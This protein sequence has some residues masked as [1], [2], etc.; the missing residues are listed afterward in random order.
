MVELG[1]PNDITVEFLCGTSACQS[2]QQV[3]VSD[4]GSFAVSCQ[5]IWEGS[6]EHEISMSDGRG[7]GWGEPNK[8]MLRQIAS[9][10]NLLFFVYTARQTYPT[11]TDVAFSAVTDVP[12]P[13][14]IFWNFGDATTARTG[15]RNVT[16]RYDTPGRY[17][18]TVALSDGRTSLTSGALSIL[19]QRPVKLNKLVHRASVLRNQTTTVSCRVDSGTDVTFLWSFGDGTTKMGQ[20]VERHAFLSTGEFLMEVTVSNRVSRGSLNSVIFVLDRPCRPPPVKN[21]GPLKLQVRRHNIIRLGVSYEGDM[22]CDASRGLRY[23]WTLSDSAGHVLP[24]PDAHKQL[25]VLP[26]HLLHHDTYTAVARVEVVGNVVYSN[27][28][29]RLEMI[30]SPPVASIQG[31]TN[32]FINHANMTALTLDG[33]RSY[34]PDFPTRPLSVKWM[35]QPVSSIKS[36]CF[37]RHVATGSAVLTFPTSSLQP[38]FDQFQFTLSVHSGALS[39]STEAFVTL[40]PSVVGRLAV[41]CL[42]CEGDQVNWDQSIS[43][44]AVCEDCEVPP[45]RIAYTWTLHLVNASSKSADEVPFCYTVDLSAP[46]A[47]KETTSMPSSRLHPHPPNSSQ[48]AY[49]F[50]AFIPTEAINTFLT[51]TTNTST[52]PPAPLLGTDVLT[53]NPG[54][55]TSFHP[56]PHDSEGSNLVESRPRQGIWKQTLIDLPREPIDARSFASYT[57]TGLSSALLSFRPFSLKPGHMYMLEAIASDRILGRT[58]L[59][60]RTKPIPKGMTCQV[61]PSKGLELYTHFGIF[62]TS[63]REDLLYEYS[64]SVGSEPPRMLYQGR[65]FQYYFS[66]PSGHPTN[67]YKVTVYTKIRSSVYGSSTQ[68]CPVTVQVRPSFFRDV[69][70]PNPDVVLSQSGLKNLSALIVLGDSTEICNYVSLLSG[71]LNRLSLDSQADHRTQSHLRN[72]LISALCKLESPDQLSRPS[73]PKRYQPDQRTLS[74]L[75]AVLSCSLEAA[76]T[77]HDVTDVTREVEPHPRVGLN[78]VKG[79]TDDDLQTSRSQQLEQLVETI[80]QTASDLILVRKGTQSAAIDCELTD[81]EEI[82][83][84]HWIL[85]MNGPVVDLTLY[86]CSTRRKVSVR[87]LVRPITVEMRPRQDKVSFSPN[88]FFFNVTREHLHQAIQLSVAFTPPPKRSFPITLLFRMFAKPSPGMHHLHKIHH[89]E[90]N[91]T[92]ITL[93]P[94]YLKTPGVGYLALFNGDFGKTIRRKHQSSRINYTLAVVASQCLSLD[95]LKGAWTP[96]GCST[97]QADSTRAVNSSLAIWCLVAFVYE[98]ADLDIFLSEA[99]D[100]TVPVVLFLCVCLYAPALMGCRRADIVSEQSRRVHYLHDNCPREPHLYA[101][102]VHTGLRS[103]YK[104]SAK[105]YVALYG[106]DGTSQTRELSVPGCTLFR[107]NSRDTFVLS[108][109]ESL[110]PVWGVRIWHDN[111]GPSPHLFVKLVEVSELGQANMESPTRLFAGQCWLSASRGDGRVER[112]LRVCTRGIGVAR[113]MRLMLCDY[114]AD[115]HMW[116]SVYSC[117][118]PHS[119]TRTQRLAVCLLLFAGYACVNALIIAQTEEAVVGRNKSLTNKQSPCVSVVRYSQTEEAVDIFYHSHLTPVSVL[120]IVVV[121]RFSSSKLQLWLHST[122]LSLASCFFLIQPI[123]ILAVGVTLSIWYRN[124]TDFQSPSRITLKAGQQLTCAL[125]SDSFSDLKK[126]KTA[127]FGFIVNPASRVSRCSHVISDF[128]LFGQR[129]RA[130][131]LR[132]VRPPTVAE[133]RLTRARRSREAFIGETLRDLC[134]LVAM[135]LLMLCIANGSS[136]SDHSRL[137]NAIRQQITGQ[138]PAFTSIRKYE[139]WRKWMQSSL[140]NFLYKNPSSIFQRSKTSI[141]QPLSENMIDDASE[142]L[143][144]AH[145]RSEAMATLEALQ[146][147]GSCVAVKVQ[148]AMYSPAP[149]LFTT[150]TLLAE[151]SPAG[152]MLTSAAV[153]SVKVYHTPTVWDYVVTVCQLLFLCLSLLHLSVQ[154]GTAW[155]KGLLGY[156]AAPCNWLHVSVILQMVIFLYSYH[157]IYRSV[158]SME[159]AE[160][161]RRTD[162]KEHVDVS[163]LA[164]REQHIRSLRGVLLLLLTAKCAT[165]LTLTR[166]STTPVTR[167]IPNLVCRKR[168]LIFERTPNHTTPLCF[169]TYYLEEFETVVDELL[170]KLNRLHATLPPVAHHVHIDDSPVPSPTSQVRLCLAKRVI[171]KVFFFFFLVICDRAALPRPSASGGES[172]SMVEELQSGRAECLSV[173]NDALERQ[174]S[175]VTRRSD[176]CL[177]RKNITCRT[178]TQAPHTEVLVEVLIHNE[179]L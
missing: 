84:S 121:V 66:L 158:E 19:I 100:V 118:R 140:L 165:M 150:V 98:A 72:V 6:A 44:Q 63:G 73:A 176:S 122:F 131:F 111:S 136:F 163:L 48:P 97:H 113:M 36:S 96:L 109:A 56:V 41:S 23:T 172:K 141:G 171:L 60:L 11:T 7:R 27:Y 138:G 154:V 22:E 76:V 164:A 9:F 107:R 80:L 123:G 168:C 161:L 14:D 29:V 129:R 38:R 61:Q 64:F 78:P 120:F 12:E 89:W 133:L 86:E 105:V 39:A 128:V 92:R 125:R 4:D 77:A 146:G 53:Q 43:V 8:Q 124:R 112:M 179:P 79:L 59:F 58:Q 47:I 116:M 67:D 45:N 10:W 2:S 87:T 33:R 17:K 160:L 175:H 157:D 99:S 69:S 32:I 57:Y 91:S 93:P 49:P 156:C 167:L 151:R 152:A 115:F 5:W 46:S 82:Q 143:P 71:I 159:V 173:L 34:D 103:A 132:L 26:G 42:Q 3:N 162:G 174:T 178:T 130:R 139:D 40:T 25:L 155:H 127:T 90:T 137:N 24:V 31:G 101:V 30:P 153:H 75:V 108:A 142:N 54:D 28:S 148:L 104:L 13:L 88:G 94:S 51:M 95:H 15:S 147:D 20:S 85:Q 68:V 106:G 117:P 18:V 114:L 134:V 70:F 74:T 119:F 135:L 102:T 126:V 1:G 21:M 166:R 55:D 81:F 52:C 170:F 144:R 35:C 16:K 62:C 177:T 169:Q 145:I 83:P 110:G 50:D 149:A 65:N 37:K